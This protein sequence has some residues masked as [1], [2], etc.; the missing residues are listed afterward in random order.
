MHSKQELAPWDVNSSIYTL[1]FTDNLDEDWYTESYLFLPVFQ[2]TQT[3]YTSAL[4]C[5]LSWVQWTHTF[6]KFIT[7]SNLF[8]LFRKDIAEKVIF[9]QRDWGKKWK[10]FLISPTP[11]FSTFTMLV[12]IYN[13]KVITQNAKM[14]SRCVSTEGD[15]ANYFNLFCVTWEL[16][17]IFKP[18]NN[19]ALTW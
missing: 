11:H 16:L 12:S 1:I 5:Y 17:R 13:I 9:F 7:Q 10:A 15:E 19:A 14:L 8:E 6:L 3:V 2:D 4:E 18:Q